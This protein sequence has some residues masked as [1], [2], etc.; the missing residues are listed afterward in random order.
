MF[1][2]GRLA[3][4]FPYDIHV[5]LYPYVVMGVFT[6]FHTDC[7]SQD[8][9]SHCWLLTRDCDDCGG[10]HPPGGL[11]HVVP[12]FRSDHSDISDRHRIASNDIKTA[13]LLRELL[14]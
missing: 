3:Y 11:F 7:F 12:G 1:S 13:R 5:V 4:K 14:T 10:A 6:K 9:Q 2:P 8:S